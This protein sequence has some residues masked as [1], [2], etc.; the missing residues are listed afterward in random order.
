MKRPLLA[1]L[2]LA[3][4]LAAC[5][6]ASAQE[7]VT[8]RLNHLPWGMHAAYYTALEKGYWKDLGLDVKIIPGHG[9]LEA[10]N[11]VGAGKEDIGLGSVDTLLVGQAKGV[12]IRAIAM[13][14]YENPSCLI[15]LKQSGIARPKDL[16]G[17]SVG[18]PP[19]STTKNILDAGLKLSGVDL[20]RIKVVNHPVGA[21]FQLL[22]A[23]KVDA[24]GG[25]CSGQVPTLEAKGFKVGAISMK[26]MGV[27]AYG[28]M[29]FTNDKTAKERPEALVKF[30]RGWLKG[31]E[32]A[33]QHVNEAIRFVLK[34]RPDRDMLEAGK[35]KMILAENRAEEAR[36]RG[37]GAMTDEK[38]QKSMDIL[39]KAGIMDRTLNV[40]EVY[41]NEFV[42][43]APEGKEFARMLFAGAPRD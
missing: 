38:W 29:L 42:E 39:V 31:H 34:Y 12:P 3:A 28:M 21:E 7:T 4:S 37:F 11:T 27:E 43:K 35:F 14:M 9:A 30:L 22:A 41:T 15:F 19:A 10:I 5:S 32:Y 20:S 40:R 17:K 25:F 23:G 26:D 8:F 33:Y 2:A 36:Q 1:M 6:A 16:E 24:F 13:D 18:H